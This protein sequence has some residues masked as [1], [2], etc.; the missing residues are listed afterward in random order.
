VERDRA[1]KPEIPEV[2]PDNGIPLRD[3]LELELP[4]RVPDG[5]AV[6]STPGR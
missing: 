6:V 5:A 4:L 3:L 2:N 1:L